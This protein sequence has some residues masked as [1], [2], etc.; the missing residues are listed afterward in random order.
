[1][2]IQGFSV[3]RTGDGSLEES[4]QKGRVERED[5]GKGGRRGQEGKVKVF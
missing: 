3:V 1:M 5:M 4:L 2:L